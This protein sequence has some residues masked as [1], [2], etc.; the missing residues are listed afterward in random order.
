MDRRA[1]AAS[2]VS[3]LASPSPLAIASLISFI[4]LRAATSPL[5][6]FTPPPSLPPSRRSHRSPRSCCSPPSPCRPARSSRCSSR[7]RRSARSPRPPLCA[8]RG[9]RGQ[10]REVEAHRPWRCPRDRRRRRRS[11][12]ASCDA[13]QSMQYM[14]SPRL[15]PPRDGEELLERQRVVFNLVRVVVEPLAMEYV[16]F[17]KLGDHLGEDAVGNHLA[18]ADVLAEEVDELAA[19][20]ALPDSSTS[21]KI[22]SA[23]RCEECA[24]DAVGHTWPATRGTGSSARSRSRWRTAR[25]STR[26]R[27]SPPG[28]RST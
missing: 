21:R 27:G 14:A 26:G 11:C 13:R 23:R 20:R 4:A 17:S 10:A 15:E 6:V 1:P 8:T 28:S 22:R 18:V 2:L 5:G 19:D 25:P 24:A 3:L 12:R 7:T 9:R 16:F